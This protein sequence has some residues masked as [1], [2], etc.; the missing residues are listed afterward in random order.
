[1]QITDI[2]HTRLWV[3]RDSLAY[4]RCQFIADLISLLNRSQKYRCEARSSPFKCSSLNVF[5]TLASHQKESLK[6][7]TIYKPASALAAVA[8][9]S[10]LL[11]VRCIGLTCRPTPE[12]P[13]SRGCAVHLPLHYSSVVLP[14]LH[15]ALS[16]QKVLLPWL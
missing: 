3:K 14:L 13:G 2:L 9:R 16:P 8:S 10:W 6:H 7:Q 12:W 15:L 1:M 11:Q 4:T 5:S